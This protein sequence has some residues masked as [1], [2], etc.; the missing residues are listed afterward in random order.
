MLQSYLLI[1]L[2][3]TYLCPNYS[4]L[5]SLL[6]RRSLLT[7]YFR[8]PAWSTEDLEFL[9]QNGDG[10]TSFEMISQSLNRSIT[11]CIG[12]YYRIKPSTPLDDHAR[13][14]L[15][16][17]IVLHGEN[18]VILG[19]LLRMNAGQCRGAYL[20]YIKTIE[21]SDSWTPSEDKLLLDLCSQAS[22]SSEFSMRSWRNI[23]H[24]LSKS[25]LACRR[26]YCYLAL[27]RDTYNLADVWYE[28]EK[29]TLRSL[30]SRWGNK[31][32]AIG[33]SF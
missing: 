29:N 15:L 1:L 16:D 23:S 7:I 4:F 33:E 18:W 17:G 19:K 11:A 10:G 28:N 13:S 5:L 27:G 30:V 26:R 21:T 24:C 32:G 6:P 14:Q 8:G 25:S 31:W 22:N 20:S 3:S 9:R 12:A 2:L